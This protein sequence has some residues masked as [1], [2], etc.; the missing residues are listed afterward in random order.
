[1]NVA[2]LVEQEISVSGMQD[3]CTIGALGIL[4]IDTVNQV[5]E[6]DGIL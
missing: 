4:S 5:I 2:D 3:S 6:Q 1:M